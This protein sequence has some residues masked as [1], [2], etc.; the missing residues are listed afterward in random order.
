MGRA[1]GTGDRPPEHFQQAGRSTRPRSPAGRVRVNAEGRTLGTVAAEAAPAA[2]PVRLVVEAPSSMPLRY[3][4]KL[5]GDAAPKK[6][7]ANG[8]VMLTFEFGHRDGIEERERYLPYDVPDE[9]YISISTAESWGAVAAGYSA[10]VERQLQAGNPAQVV[11]RVIAGKTGREA[12]GSALLAEVHKQ[13]RYTAV[14]LG[15]ASIVPRDSAE[16]GMKH[17]TV[18]GIGAAIL[19]IV[20]LISR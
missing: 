8:T 14:E 1:A 6:S 13:V 12:V 5:M 10:I 17:W 15:E 2:A 16:R 3:A 20:F 18:I 4:V 7:E 11:R 19:I 9:S